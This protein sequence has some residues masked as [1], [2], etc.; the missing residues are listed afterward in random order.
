MIGDETR[1]H[2]TLSWG[3]KQ[4]ILKWRDRSLAGEERDP[5]MWRGSPLPGGALAAKDGAL[6]G[7]RRR[8]CTPPD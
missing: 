1:F 6:S 5:A 4:A 3:V 2:G 7:R 8:F